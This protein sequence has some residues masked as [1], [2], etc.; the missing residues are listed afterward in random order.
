MD[1]RL[2]SV[3]GLEAVQQIKSLVP[4]AQFIVHSWYVDP[5]TSKLMENEGVYRFLAKGTAS[6]SIVQAVEEALEHK[7]W[8][9]AGST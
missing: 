3:D 9:E 6:Q 5:A 7:R 4:Q 1:L 2:P 8:L